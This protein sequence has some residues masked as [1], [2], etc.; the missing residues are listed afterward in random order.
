MGVDTRLATEGPGVA[1]NSASR[2]PR[3]R[4]AVDMPIYASAVKVS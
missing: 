4:N 1:L 3:E 2:S